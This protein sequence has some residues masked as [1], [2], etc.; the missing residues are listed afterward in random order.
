[1]AFIGQKGHII[2]LIIGA[3]IILAIL[4]V[5][6]TTFFWPAKIIMQVVMIFT[7]YTTVRG[8]MG[9]G[10]LTIM[11]SA[12]LIYFM[13]FKY[14]EIFLSLYVLQLL[15][16]LQFLSVIIWGVGTTMRK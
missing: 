10:N 14:F 5:I 13:V 8:L 9:S 1:M 16:G 3:F 12:I 11:I 7:L 2:F 4:P 6:L 15:L